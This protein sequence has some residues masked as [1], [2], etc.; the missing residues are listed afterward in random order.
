MVNRVYRKIIDLVMRVA[1][2]PRAGDAVVIRQTANSNL[3]SFRGSSHEKKQIYFLLVVSFLLS[4]CSIK[5][6]IEPAELIKGHELCIIE[7][8]RVRDGFLIE[9]KSALSVKL[10]PFKVVSGRAIP[11]S[12]EWTAT[13]T[14]RWSWDFTI[15]MSYAEIKIFHNGNLDGEAIYDSTHGG[16]TFGKFIDAEPKIREL[17]N[18]LLGYESASLFGRAFG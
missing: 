16:L 12:C 9:F 14:A 7:N 17:V 2:R 1:A 4:A 11:S 13:Y 5:Q 10:I 18:K 3:Q 8:H 6:T 15:Y